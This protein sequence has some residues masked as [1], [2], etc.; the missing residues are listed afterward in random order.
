MKKKL[1]G[2]LLSTAMVATMLAGCGN[3]QAEPSETAA[4]PKEEATA[5]VSEAA[6][7]TKEEATGESYKG[8]LEL[9]HF[10]TSEESQGNG[11]SDG[12]RTV[13][14]QWEAANP[15]IQLEQQVLA[16]DDYKTQV[17][18]LAAADDLPDVFLLQGMNT[19][20]WAQQGLVLDMTDY[21][22][23][24]PYYKDYNESYFTPFTT[25]GKIYGLPALT[26]GTCT[27]VVYDKSV[28]GDTFPATWADVE[29][30]SEELVKDGITPIAFGNGGKWQAN[31]CFLSTLGDRYTGADWFKSMI[32]KGGSAFTDDTFVAALAETQRLFT[33]TKVFNKDFNAITNEDA[34][35][36]YIDGSAAAFVGGNWDVSYLQASL[37]G[38]DRLENTGFAVVPQSADA[39]SQRNSQNIGLGYAI[40][41]N[42]EVANDPAKL[43]AALNLAYT[44]TGP[45]F[46]NFV[47]SKY[48]LGGLTAAGDVDF[49]QFDKWTQDFYNFSYVDTEACEIYDSY[50]T[51]AVWD[52][53]NTDLQ[54]MMNGGM[55]PEDVAANAQ[56]AYE[57]N[58]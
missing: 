37:E 29:K 35:E 53:L 56:K 12:F 23:A 24:S 40:A 57:S 6:D 7:E 27:V 48:A 28:W 44:V 2:V 49:S 26:G 31:S 18:T 52:V 45:D 30:K 39:G 1:L 50:I 38:S 21:I 19:I 55:T 13:I 17:A 54:T 42:P 11:G 9:M 43:E 51:S 46:S 36:Y 33:K 47:A 58:Y 20:S 34:R 25:D 22:K 32:D 41:I 5:E 8:T 15:D 4:A 10:S 14:A 16:N 3:T